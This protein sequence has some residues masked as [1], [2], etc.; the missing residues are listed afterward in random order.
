MGR[1]IGCGSIGASRANE[2][3]EGAARL[4]LGALFLATKDTRKI[5]VPPA[6]DP[7]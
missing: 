7:E 2:K 5:S 1:H 3:K 4:E 6:S